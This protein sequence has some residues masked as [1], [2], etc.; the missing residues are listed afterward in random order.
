MSNET[1]A[2]EMYVQ[3][4]PDLGSRSLVSVGGGSQPIWSPDG[5]E[6]LYGRGGPPDAMMRVTVD[7]AGD[8]PSALTVG[9]PEFLFD[10][11][12]LAGLDRRNYAVSPNGQRLLMITAGGDASSARINVV[13]DWHQELLERVPIN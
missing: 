11:R 12:Y 8:D 7:M 13:L 6:L 5:R 1:G 4:Y 9:T 2:M 10:Y 3:R